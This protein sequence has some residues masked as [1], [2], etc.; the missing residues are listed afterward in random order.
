MAAYIGAF[1]MG[2]GLDAK[3]CRYS[4]QGFVL[5][6]S[7]EGAQIFGVRFYSLWGCIFSGED[8]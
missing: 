7:F 3:G 8:I 6:R 2:R 5:N 1:G 4:V